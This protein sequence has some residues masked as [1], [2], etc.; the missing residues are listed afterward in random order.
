VEKAGGYIVA[1]DRKK[2]IRLG[3]KATSAG[4]ILLIA[5]KGHENYQILGTKKI[6]FDDRG[7]TLVALSE[8][9]KTEASYAHE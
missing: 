6:A 4:D 3:L 2:A 7:E 1:P 8:L 9:G 5:G